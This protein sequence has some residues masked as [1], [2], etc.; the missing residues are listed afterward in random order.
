MNKLK[1]GQLV[2][3]KTAIVDGRKRLVPKD[4]EGESNIESFEIICYYNTHKDAPLN[5]MVL[6]DLDI[7][8]WTINKFYILHY[9]LDE[10]YL[11]CKFYDINDSFFV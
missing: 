5:Y 1:K 7:I 11:N 4:W 9:D 3:I 2:K 8:G 10:K 6:V